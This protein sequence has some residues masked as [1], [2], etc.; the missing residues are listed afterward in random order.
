MPRRRLIGE[1]CALLAWLVAAGCGA[2]STPA[3]KPAA[4]LSSPAS[5]VLASPAIEGVPSPMP[6]P[7][8]GPDGPFTSA[9]THDQSQGCYDNGG[10]PRCATAAATA[11][12]GT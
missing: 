6:H 1:A 10:R 9:G 5:P 11:R 2:S 8:P 12:S 4:G 7:G 3:S